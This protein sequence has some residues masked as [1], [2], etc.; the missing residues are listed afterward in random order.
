MIFLD[1]ET[2]GLHGMIVL[3]QWAED[4][5]P[6]HLY[7][8]WRNPISET[9]ALIEKFANSEICGFNLAFDWFHIQKLYCVLSAHHDHSEEPRDIIDEL[10]MLEKQA[11]F[12]PCVKPKSACDLMLLA[13]KGKYQSLMA[14]KNIKISKVPNAIAYEL[15]EHLEKTIQL[16]D[17]YFARRRDKWAPR[18]KVY[19]IEDEP[20]F[21][22]V[23]LKFHP[24]G[25]LK[26]LAV[27]TGVAEKSSLLVFNDVEVDKVFR[28]KEYGWAPFAEA[29]GRPGKWNWAW[30]EVIH[31]HIAHWAFYKPARKY[32]EDDVKYTRGLYENFG[33]P[34]PGD[35]DSIL[36]C[37]VGSV[38]WRGYKLN[39]EKIKAQKEAVLEKLKGIPT[40]PNSARVYIQQLMGEDEIKIMGKSTA[41]VALEG[42]ADWKC[43]CTFEDDPP[44]C[45]ICNNDR[46]HPAAHRAEEVLNA[47]KGLK[48]VEL[49]DKLLLAGRFHASFIVIGTLSSRMAGTDGLNAQGINHKTEVRECFTLADDGFTLAG[50]DFDSFEV[51][52]ADAA[53]DDPKLREVLKSGKKIHALFAMKIYKGK[54]YEDI[55]ATKG[56]KLKDLYLSGKA[57]VFAMIYGGD[58]NTL[59]QK[60]GIDVEIAEKAYREF[61][62]DYPDIGVARRKVFDMFCSMRQPGG[63]GSK[64]EWHEP[65]DYIESL[66]GFRR[67]FTL[68]N[69]ICKALF[70]LANKPPKHWKDIKDKVVRRERQQTVGGACSSALYGAAFQIQAANMRAAAN[71][72]IQSSGATITKKVQR[73]IWEVQ[74]HGVNEWRVVPCNVHDEIMAP[75]KP[76]Y[77][78]E[79]ATTVNETVE[80]FRPR[81]P[82]IQIGWDNNLASWAGK[83]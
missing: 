38:R 20:D 65:S 50:G 53:Y 2:C 7:E 73:N 26:N 33:S 61:I 41:K 70:N 48:E 28:P 37:M 43:D 45:K 3:I 74:P 49:Y 66:M 1:T 17:I 6:I 81:V 23:V 31:H 69:Q 52:L 44:D 34:E 12:G 27:H 10:A 40:A 68:E 29:V 75:V 42:I 36:A 60:Q 22:N 5:G 71:H 54:S 63:I 32:A 39:I 18:W 56:D 62:A 59:V 14:R 4:D 78:D 30:P 51:V 57:G 9:L 8:V 16:D 76:G 58:H 55:L 35:D 21:K 13:R 15:A 25:G 19:D 11:R 80:S 67:Y 79:V 64:V 83:S 77:E 47:R 72:V 24:A 82:L 46:R